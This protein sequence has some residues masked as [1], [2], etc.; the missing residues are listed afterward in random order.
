MEEKVDNIYIYLWEELNTV[1]IGRTKNLKVRNSQHKNRKTE[2]T[3]KFSA[4]NNVEHPNMVI[5]E[6]GLTI[7]EGVE[8]EKYWI[9]HY[10]N[11]TNYNVLNIRQGGQIGNQHRVY[12]DEEIREHRKEYYNNNKKE[13]ASYQKMYY[14]NNKEKVKEYFDTHKK[15]KKEYDKMYS[16]KWYEANKEKK[17]EYSRTHRKTKGK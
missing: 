12:T 3:Y 14:Q 7:S 13:R 1:Y 15:E 8:R 4:E 6:K 17:K 16:R 10:R 11:E 5:I 2:K 9:N